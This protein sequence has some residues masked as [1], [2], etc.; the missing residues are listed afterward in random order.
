MLTLSDGS[1][2]IL[3]SA[4]NGQIAMQQ[5]SSVLK[6]D[7]QIIYMYPEG[8]KDYDRRQQTATGVTYNTMSTPAADNTG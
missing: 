1:T 8:S 4:A 5:G 3:D 2:I 6:K 7:G